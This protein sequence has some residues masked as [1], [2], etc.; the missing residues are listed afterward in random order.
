VRELLFNV[1]KHARTE[2]AQ[3]SVGIVDGKLRLS[4]SDSGAGFDPRALAQPASA[5]LGLFSIRER[6]EALGGTLEIDSARGRGTRVTL[7]VPGGTGA[8]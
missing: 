1:S 8:C 5:G 7:T 4:V 3:V 6:L 2:A